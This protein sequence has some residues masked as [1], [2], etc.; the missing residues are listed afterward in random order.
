MGI[1]APN[2]YHLTGDAVDMKPEDWKNLSKEQQNQL[3]SQYNV[4]Y[5]NNHYHIEPK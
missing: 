2:S 3:K 5:H 1:G 4:V